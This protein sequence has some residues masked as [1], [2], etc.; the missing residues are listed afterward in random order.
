MGPQTT[1]VEIPRR[2][3]VTLA[4]YLRAGSTSRPPISWASASPSVASGLSLLLSQV[5]AWNTAQAVWALRRELEG[6]GYLRQALAGAARVTYRGQRGTSVPARPASGA[7]M[8]ESTTSPSLPLIFVWTRYGTEAGE[9]V[10][11]ILARKEQERL[12]NDG[13]LYWGIGNALGR[14]WRDLI[15]PEVLFSPML[16]RPKDIDVNPRSV[17]WWTSAVR[18]DGARFELPSTVRVTGRFDA[19][20]PRPHYALECHSDTPIDGGLVLGT[21]DIRRITNL[22]SGKP[23][24]ASQ[25]TAVVRLDPGGTE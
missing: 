6:E 5:G 19:T 4:A 24:G 7:V 10:S 22:V 3:L 15:D 11:G 8:S 1:K 2:E 12:A 16:S 20:S 23:I 17:A 18:I 13:H 25:V 21:V 9:Q 14:A